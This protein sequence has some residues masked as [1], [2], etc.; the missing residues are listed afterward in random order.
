MGKIFGECYR[1][2]KDDGILLVWFTHNS[3]DAWK[4]IITALYV[5]GFYV[6]KIWPV[7]SELLTRL[8]SKGNGT[9]LN[10]TL[11]VVARKKKKEEK[12]DENQ[13]KDYAFHLMKGIYNVLLNLEATKSEIRIFL[14]AAAMCAATRANLP[15]DEDQIKYC[16]SKLIPFLVSFADEKLNLLI[17]QLDV[18]RI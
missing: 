9:V 6:T 14:R 10:K 18:A 8:V 2:L 1:V 7:T 17:S 16:E 15:D 12:I 4:S 5:G 3:I 13:L 11:I